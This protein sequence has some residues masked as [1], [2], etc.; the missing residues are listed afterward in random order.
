MRK[1]I[2]VII[3]AVILVLM[4]ASCKDKDELPAVP[5][6]LSP[7]LLTPTPPAP[8]PKPPVKPVEP[9]PEMPDIMPP[10][11]LIEDLAGFWGRIDGSTATIPLTAALYDLLGNGGGPPEHNTTSTAYYRLINK[12]NTDLIFVTHPSEEELEL[13]AEQGVELEVIPIVKDALVF[14]IN[15]ENPVENITLEQLRQIYSGRIKNWMELDG[16]EESIIPY[17]R[18]QNSGSQ[19]LLIKLVMDGRQPMTAPTSWIAESMGSLVEVVS[20]YDNARDAIGYSM[21]YYVN[22]MYGNSRFKLL[23]IDGVKP[24][25]YS[26]MNGEYP[27][28]DCYYAVIRKDTPESHQ[29]RKLINWILTDDGQTIAVRAGYIP[30][31][32]MTNLWP[33]DEM[34]PIYI[35]DTENSSGTGGTAI[36]DS[37]DDAQPRNGVRPP[38][39]DMF[40][41]GFNYIQYIN[42]E[43]IR[44][45]DRLDLEDWR[46][47]TLSEQYQMRPFTGIPNDY[48]NYEINNMS[49]LI[50]NFAEGNPFFDRGINFYINLTEDISPYGQGISPYTITY[51]YARRLTP[52]VDLFTLSVELRDKP[53][54]SER[55]NERLKK[56]VRTLPGG[57]ESVHMLNNFVDWHMGPPSDDQGPT[58]WAYNLQPSVGMWREYLAVTYMLATY[59]GPSTNMPMLNTICFNINTGDVVNLANELPDDLDYA[60]ASIYTAMDFT[61]LSDW[62]Y[63]N[64]ENMPDGYIPAAGSV[65]TDAWIGYNSPSLCLT[66]PSGRVLQINFWGEA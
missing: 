64:Q 4:L 46:P 27:L 28:G 60:H 56:W 15:A 11:D 63:P 26:I 41:N 20:S 16:L 21:F 31:K 65:I 13:A 32:M 30:L 12:D 23:G 25:R 59:D 61:K 33:I 34:D 66:E 49:Y 10:L 38:L 50:I 37:V 1:Y 5:T 6:D 19:T 36:K 39:S 55:I 3:T 45:F 42:Y 17:Q 51:D 54:V 9:T 44:E 2:Y 48:P 35:G 14:L 24:T 22:N 43:I 8:P 47:L 40:F 58:D 57:R 29:A 53:E 7:P 52:R 62:G 18:T